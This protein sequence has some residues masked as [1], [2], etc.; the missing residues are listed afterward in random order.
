[1]RS[2]CTYFDY[3][4]LTRAL[5]MMSSLY[6]F[7]K[8]IKFYVLA[9]DKKTTNKLR[10]LNINYINIIDLSNFFKQYK[11]L[12]KQKKIRPI[13]EFC[14]LLTPYIIEYCLRK[15]NCNKIYYADADL[16]FFDNCSFI[17]NKLSKYSVIASEHN[18]D[19]KNKYQEN[20]NGIFNV[21]FLGFKKNSISAKCLDIWKKQCFFSTTTNEGFSSIIRGDQLYLNMWPKLLKK[22]F[23][24]IKNKFFNIGA[25]NIEQFSFRTKERKLYS[26]KNKVFMI[27]ANFIEFENSKIVINLN[28]KLTL[29]NKIVCDYYIKISEENDIGFLSLEKVGLVKK[30]FAYLKYVLKFLLKAVIKYNK[31]K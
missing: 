14:F 17:T 6:S 1:M 25:W 31:I 27:H 20:I 10:I 29:I 30:T 11:F 18:F 21:G 4:Y 19:R 24:P 7:D 16:I 5:T 13:S 2:F 12:K 15:F 28:P 9:L 22:D 26:N 8:N 23:S 3:H